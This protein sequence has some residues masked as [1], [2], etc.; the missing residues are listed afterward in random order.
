[1]K[2]FT[3][4]KEDSVLYSFACLCSVSSAVV[5]ECCWPACV[6][7]RA[8]TPLPGTLSWGLTCGTR[9]AE[10]VGRERRL[11]PSRSADGTWQLAD[12]WGVAVI[13]AVRFLVHVHCSDPGC[14]VSPGRMG[15]W[16]KGSWRTM[17]ARSPMLLQRRTSGTGRR[18]VRSISATRTKRRLTGGNGSGGRSVRRRSAGPRRKGSRGT[19]WGSPSSPRCLARAGANGR[20]QAQAALF[21]GVPWG[22]VSRLYRWIGGMWV[23]GAMGQD[24]DHAWG[25]PRSSREP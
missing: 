22:R 6:Y 13:A 17:E 5:V 2:V 15:S 14:V 4:S 11:S 10:L 24:R 12:A 3:A 21:H 7:E 9:T 1:M 16:R 23:I 8:R 25:E 18:G 19:R 20:G